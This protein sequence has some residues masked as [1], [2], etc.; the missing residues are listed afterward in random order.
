MR[1][2]ISGRYYVDQLYLG[3]FEVMDS[4]SGL[5]VAR[6]SYYF[7]LFDCHQ[8]AESDALLR[9]EAIAQALNLIDFDWKP[10]ASK[11]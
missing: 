8:E 11:I 10:P 9:A 7:D 3:N 1:A 5:A 4:D 6:C 2:V